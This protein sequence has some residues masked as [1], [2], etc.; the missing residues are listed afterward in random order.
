ML[1]LVLMINSTPLVDTVIFLGYP[2]GKKWW[3]LFDLDT[4]QFFD[5]RDVYFFENQFS[6]ASSSSDHA[7]TTL[8]SSDFTVGPAIHLLDDFLDSS[9][10]SRPSN[11]TPT[12]SRIPPHLSSGSRN[13]QPPALP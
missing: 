9:Y 7:T 3:H 4:H 12:P 8:V 11:I 5:S 6:F 2:S 13:G 1:T 10:S